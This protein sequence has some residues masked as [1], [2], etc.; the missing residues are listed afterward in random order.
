MSIFHLHL[1][2]EI[3][4]PI[5]GYDFFVWYCDGCEKYKLEK[6]SPKSE[7]MNHQQFNEYIVK[8]VNR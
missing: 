6:N 7:W 2:Q 5:G 8:I 3:N 1:W 4:R